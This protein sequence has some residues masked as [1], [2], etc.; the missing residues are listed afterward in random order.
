MWS[1]WLSRISCLAIL[2][3]YYGF[4]PRASVAAA[5]PNI[6]VI[7]SDDGGYNEYGFN[8]AISGPG[9]TPTPTQAYTPNLDAL[10]AQS[11]IGRQAY[12][13]PLCGESRAALLTGVTN[14]RL[15]LEENLCNFTPANVP[16]GFAAGQPTIASRGKT[17]GYTTGMVGKW[18]EKFTSGV[19]TPTDLGFDEFLWILERPA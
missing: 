6:I 16:L 10:A 13:Q 8:A 1:P 18:H 19:N 5:K 3:G 12:A 4:C 11:V 2:L 7:L 15:G 14:Q 17:L 9:Q